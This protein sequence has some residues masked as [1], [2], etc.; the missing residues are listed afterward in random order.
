MAGYFA[1]PPK[2]AVL[3]RADPLAKGLVGAWLFNER[4]G[5]KAYDVA[6]GYTATFASG[7][8]WVS[9][10]WGAGLS[11]DATAAT[12]TTTQDI[13]AF[14]TKYSFALWV[15]NFDRAADREG[16]VI[17]NHRLLYRGI[18]TPFSLQRAAG[19]FESQVSTVT[20]NTDQWY[21]VVVTNNG[22][23]AGDIKIYVDGKDTTG[24]ATAVTVV[25]SGTT[26]IGAAGGLPSGSLIGSVL[27]WS[28]VLSP[29]DVRRLFADQYVAFRRRRVPVPLSVQAAAPVTVK[30]RRSIV[31][32][33]ARIGSR[34]VMGI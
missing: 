32:L 1:K 10:R 2:G 24:V 23:V 16:L 6:R 18:T 5:L 15:N 7:P 11:F 3:N 21:H 28:R 31:G 17:G 33:G 8:A 20:P 25:G 13:T 27:I 12:A 26:T 4:A 30:F 22:G 14:G 34:Q 9:T 29:A 19:A